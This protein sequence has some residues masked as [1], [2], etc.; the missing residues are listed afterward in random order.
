MGTLGS[1]DDWQRVIRNPRWR[2]S[3]SHY[4]PNF[5]S[6]KDSSS[7]ASCGEYSDFLIFM[8][9]SQFCQISFLTTICSNGV[10]GD[11]ISVLF[12]D[13]LRRGLLDYCETWVE[14]RYPFLAPPFCFTRNNARFSPL[15]FSVLLSAMATVALL[16]EHSVRGEARI[17]HCSAPVRRP[18]LHSQPPSS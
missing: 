4:N 1:V 11:K 7:Y 8:I 3:E 18:R 17:H 5:V 12:K 15:V 13:I 9:I 6:R 14:P 16:S 10:H 2:F